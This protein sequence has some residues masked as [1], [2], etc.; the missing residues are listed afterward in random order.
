MICF[1]VLGCCVSRDIIS[2]PISGGGVQIMRCI[3]CHPYFMFGASPQHKIEMDAL[4]S[5]PLSDY[6]IVYIMQFRLDIPRCRNHIITCH[7][8]YSAT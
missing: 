1:D 5:Y 4:N 3:T 2:P 6:L 7:D 8:F